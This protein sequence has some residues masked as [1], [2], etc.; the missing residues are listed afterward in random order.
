MGKLD[1]KVALVTGAGTGLGRAIAITFAK[2]GATVVLNGRR[3]DKLREVEKEIG[4]HAIVIPADMADEAG[5]KG[6]VEKLQTQTNGKLDILVNNAG[7]VNAM[8]K[9]DEMTLEQW[10]KM[11]DLNLFTQVLATRELL[12]ILRESK[13]GKLISVTSG[14]VN[15]FM[16]G[17]GAYSATKAA[18]EKM[19]K[20]VAE[21]EKDTGV[22]VNMFDPLNAISEGNPQGQYDPMDIVGVLVDLAAAPGVEKHGEII[23]PEV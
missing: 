6:L 1:G 15:F 8:G 21:E 10:K 16:E 2:E 3:E 20:T 12:P 11:L 18:A 4:D 17:M 7:G 9:V 13:S 22:Q 19:M 5:V 14:M 23:K